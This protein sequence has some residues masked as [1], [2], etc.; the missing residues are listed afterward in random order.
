[1]IVSSSFEFLGWPFPG[2]QLQAL[3]LLVGH[4]GWHVASLLPIR[5]WRLVW[6][7]YCKFAKLTGE[8]FNSQ[9]IHF[10]LKFFAKFPANPN[11]IEKN[12]KCLD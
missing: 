4:W 7:F 6:N 11:S 12:F 8:R 1:M 3:Y 5:E 2:V 9:K 10:P